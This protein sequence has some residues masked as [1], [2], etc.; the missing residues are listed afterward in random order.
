MNLVVFM[1]EINGISYPVE[2]C[3]K[4][5]KNAYIRIKEGNVIFV[6]VP[7]L[8]SDKK[9]QL[10]LEQNKES[11]SRMILKVQ[12]KTERE[13]GFY[14]LGN[15]YYVIYTPL[16][17]IEFVKDKLYVKDEKTLDRFLNQER[18]RLFLERLDFWY[19]QFEEK[20]PYPTLKIRKMKT[21]WGVC[22][23]SNKTVTLNTELIRYT[24]DKLDYVIIH[25]LSHFIHF[26]HSASFWKLVEK[27][28]PNYKK[29]RKELR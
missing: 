29:I 26:N 19:D 9:I 25:E 22:N 15:R 3:R 21:R 27:Y 14:F 8:Y 2:I 20:I 13:E 5:N 11:I 18:K 7:K 4:N 24:V 10:L 17:E 1:L 23:R 16:Y 28:E 12:E 6:T